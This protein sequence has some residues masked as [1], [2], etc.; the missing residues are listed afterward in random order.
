MNGAVTARSGSV[1][2]LCGGDYRVWADWVGA[3]GG[4]GWIDCPLCF[5]P[6]ESKEGVM[7]VVPC[8]RCGRLKPADGDDWCKRCEAEDAVE[9]LAALRGKRRDRPA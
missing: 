1:C 8:L 6:A 2:D 5:P 9:V 3:D 7:N 4:P